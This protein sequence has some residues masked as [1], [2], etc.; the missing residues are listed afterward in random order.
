M[1]VGPQRFQYPKTPEEAKGSSHEAA[2]RLHGVGSVEPLFHESLKTTAPWPRAGRTKENPRGY[3]PARVE[4]AV[5]NP[6][7]H[8]REMDPRHLHSTQPSVTHS[9]VSYYMGEEYRKTGRTFADMNQAGNRWP[10]VYTDVQGRNKLLSGHHRAT[11]ALLRGEQ[12]RAIHI[13]E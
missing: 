4:S 2:H 3:D 13:E 5:A 8:I 7:A 10:V 1:T 9:G 12:F 6:S 11:A